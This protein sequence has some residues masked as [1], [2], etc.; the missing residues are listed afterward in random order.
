[1][2]KQPL[3]HHMNLCLLINWLDRQGKKCIANISSWNMETMDWIGWNLTK[4]PNNLQEAASQLQN[5]LKGCAPINITSKDQRRWGNENYTVRQGYAQIISQMT[6]LPKD[7][8]WKY[9]WSNYSP[10][11]VNS[12]CWILAQGKLLTGE[13]LLKRNMYGP[14]RCE[15]CGKATKNSHLIFLL[16]PFTIMVWKTTLQNLHARIRWPVQT[17]EFFSD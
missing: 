13:N 11:K 5:M 2:R 3:W 6:C 12:F 4:I 15:I 8:I 9:I 17:K 7:K 16:C 10:P 14:Y 1:M